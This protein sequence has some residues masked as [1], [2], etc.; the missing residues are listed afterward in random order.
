[1]LYILHRARSGGQFEPHNTKPGNPEA[2]EK[3]GRGN[4]Y[5]SDRT[6]GEIETRIEEVAIKNARGACRSRSRRS[7]HIGDFN[8][9]NGG[10]GK[11]QILKA[12]SRLIGQAQ[13]GGSG[14]G[15]D[16]L[17]RIIP[18]EITRGIQQRPVAEIDTR[19]RQLEYPC[20]GKTGTRRSPGLVTALK[21][22]GGRYR[23]L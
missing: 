16:D 8:Q 20:V 19:R 5:L 2:E 22:F 1:M 23:E 21:G 17:D 10:A 7:S 12:G 6:L 18:A 9:I 14:R 3:D 4:G 11:M 13:D 15:I